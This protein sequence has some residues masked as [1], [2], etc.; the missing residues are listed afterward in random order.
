MQK[1]VA[2]STFRPYYLIEKGDEKVVIMDPLSKKVKSIGRK[3]YDRRY[4]EVDKEG[5]NE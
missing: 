1:V 4:I 5:D 3:A 2:R